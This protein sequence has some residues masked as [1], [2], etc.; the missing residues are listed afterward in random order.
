MYSL[1][2]LLTA[3]NWRTLVLVL[4]DLL[5]IQTCLRSQPCLHSSP[6]W[7]FKL[8]KWDCLI[9]CVLSI[10]TIHYCTLTKGTVDLK[11]DQRAAWCS[12][13]KADREQVEMLFFQTFSSKVLFPAKGHRFL[14]VS[15][16]MD[17][18]YEITLFT[19]S[20]KWWFLYLSS[21]FTEHYLSSPNMR[22]THLCG[23]STSQ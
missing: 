18:W 2:H 23:E 4:I 16:L 10:R 5:K 14:S 20:E 9:L 7:W 19:E 3:L 22:R 13:K 1:C 12:Q 17:M 21:H 15:N 8:W 11:R 6:Y